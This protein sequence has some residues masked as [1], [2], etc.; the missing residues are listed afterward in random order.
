MMLLTELSRKLFSGGFIISM[1]LIICFGIEQ[2]H[3]FWV[4]KGMKK[5]E[6]ILGLN[7]GKKQHLAPVSYSLSI[8]IE[9]LPD[10]IGSVFFF[11]PRMFIVK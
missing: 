4:N 9:H 7:L 11:C 3:P 1:R 5:T 2:E 6:T 10:G 8:S